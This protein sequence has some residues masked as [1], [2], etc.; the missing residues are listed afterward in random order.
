LLRRDKAAGDA[1]LIS[2][3]RLTRDEEWIQ[4]ARLPSARAKML[5]FSGP[6]LALNTDI[7]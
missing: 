5:V 7:K 4:F 1:S 3:F 6:T 2:T